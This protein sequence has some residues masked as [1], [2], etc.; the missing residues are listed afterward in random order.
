M[1][2]IGISLGNVSYSANWVIENNL[3]KKKDDGYNTCPFDLMISNYKGVIQCI[4]DDFAH[5]CNPSCLELT[6][7]CIINTMYNFNFKY[8]SPHHADL[9]LHEK[10]PEGKMHFV[11]NNYVHFIERYNKRIRSFYEYIYDPK[12]FI[13]FI[14][15]FTNE[16]N[17]NNDCAEL[18]EALSKK[19]PHLKYSIVVI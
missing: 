12:I 1:V 4:Y 9:C 19:F 3:R 14:I 6:D 11:N 10:W 18:R 8:E 17:P 13:Y 16:T 15:Q 5:F 7:N 2:N